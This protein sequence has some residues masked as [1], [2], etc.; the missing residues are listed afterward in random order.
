MTVIPSE[1]DGSLVAPNGPVPDIARSAF[2]VFRSGRVRSVNYKP[3]IHDWKFAPRDA[4][5]AP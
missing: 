2:F 3:C 1:V 4:I 5:I